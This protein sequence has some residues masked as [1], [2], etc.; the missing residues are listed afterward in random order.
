MLP[1]RIYA[2]S[3]PGGRTG[4][5]AATPTSPMNGVY[6]RE[7]VSA[8]LVGSAMHAG[9]ALAGRKEEAEDARFA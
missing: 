1:E 3:D 8:T 2:I 4:R 5:W 7:D 6:V 9:Y